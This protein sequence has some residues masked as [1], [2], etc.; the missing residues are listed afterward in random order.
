MT[1]NGERVLQFI[2][3]TLQSDK[4]LRQEVAAIKGLEIGTVRIGAFTSISSQWLPGIIKEFQNQHSAIEVKLAEGN[5]DDIERWILNGTVDFGFLSLPASKSFEVIPIKKDKMFCV[6]PSNH[7]YRHQNT[8]LF[9]QIKTEPFI[10]TKWGSTDDVRRILS[11]NNVKPK[12]KYEVAEERTIIAMVQNGLGIS[13]LPEMV[14]VGDIHNI[15]LIDLEKSA[16]RLIGIGLNSIKN[17]SPAAR[18]FF[19]MRTILVNAAGIYR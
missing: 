4:K 7:P 17:I 14:L 5:Y 3:E 15:C 8:I 16:Y 19:G 10:I 2:R 13:I 9:D 11:E 6:L 18:K 1:S 12:I